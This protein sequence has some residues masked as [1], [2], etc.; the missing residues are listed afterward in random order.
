MTG[1]IGAVIGIHRLNIARMRRSAGGFKVLERIDWEALIAGLIPKAASV[2]A[3]GTLA[4]SDGSPMPR[5]LAETD[6]SP[7]RKLL[8]QIIIGQPSE[9]SE[10]AAVDAGFS[11]GEAR[12]VHTLSLVRTAPKRALDVL[13]TMRCDTA[14]EVYLRE[15]LF[16]SER[17][18]ALNLEL[19]AFNVRRRLRDAIARYG[20]SPPLYF[21][22]ARAA[23]ILGLNRRAIDDLAR[24]VY[25]SQQ[26]PFYVAAVLDTPYIAEARPP[27]VFQCRQS[28]AAADVLERT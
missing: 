25:F 17:V 26:A 28:S 24:A 1:Y 9:I 27:L 19:S 20:D 13:E 18:N 16:L 22:R 6:D 4:L 2:A 12:F 5:T 23:A 8:R 3:R 7:R 15:H 10:A 21:A 14:P 11:G